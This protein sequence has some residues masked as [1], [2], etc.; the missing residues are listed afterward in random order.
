MLP[1]LAIKRTTLSWTIT[2]ILGQLTFGG[3]LPIMKS[4][5]ARIEQQARTPL[6]ER[7]ILVS[8]SL[9][10]LLFVCY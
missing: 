8:R 1:T 5:N 9:S 4:E 2:I 10:L 6:V 3:P 7:A